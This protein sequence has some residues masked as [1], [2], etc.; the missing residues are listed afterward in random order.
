M[1]DL[2][3]H[4]NLYEI[5]GVEPT[6]TQDEIK[7][8]YRRKAFELH[9]DRNQDDPQATEK[10]QELSDAYETLKDPQR[11][12]AY[13]RFG[14]QGETPETPEDI[15]AFDLL[16]QILGFGRSRRPPTGDK[17]TPTIRL[18]NIPLSTINSGGELSTKIKVN[19]VCTECHGKG[20]IDGVEYP[21]CPQCGGAGSLSPGGLQF[22]FPC[23][24][25]HS[26]GY[27][28]PPNKVCPHCGGKKVVPKQKV[29]KVNVPIGIADQ[30]MIQVPSEGDEY[31]GKITAD[32]VF[33][34]M[35]RAEK[36]FIRDGDDLV[37]VKKL[38]VLEMKTGTHFKLKTLNGKVYHCYTEADKP[39][40]TNV[41]RWIPHEGLP[42]Y[43]NTQF[44]GNI[45]IIFRM[46]FKGP[47]TQSV[48]M[49]SSLVSSTKDSY[50]LERAPQ[51]IQERYFDP[52]QL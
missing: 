18:L 3:Q 16:T 52:E 43:G 51:E 49:I 8:A 19:I 39:I 40:D 35:S 25:C 33:M 41:V 21:T 31:P 26:I 22:L 44:R 20:S 48:R 13:D 12:Q 29:V 11:R 10:F 4:A 37:F 23:D 15:Q 1:C 24:A 6:A 2:S 46:G 14:L 30:E 45:Y 47:I 36:D 28:I 34:T 7:R 32:I 9:P 27:I 38:S 17:L 5:L 42:S 50:F